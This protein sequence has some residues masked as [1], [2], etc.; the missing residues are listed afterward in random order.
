MLS[1]ASA[2]LVEAFDPHR[3]ALY[4]A[5]FPKAAVRPQC[6]A[7]RRR[8]QSRAGTRPSDAVVRGV[9]V[10]GNGCVSRGLALRQA[11]RRRF[12]PAS[13]TLSAK[14]ARTLCR[15]DFTTVERGEHLA[16][17]KKI[18]EAKWRPAKNR[19]FTGMSDAPLP[20]RPFDKASRIPSVD[21]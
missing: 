2:I 5:R 7:A 10:E 8:A 15:A 16:R 3:S 17:R 19:H 12:E 18:Y 20:G 13:A 11:R 14:S 9:A 4:P 6:G 1:A 21:L